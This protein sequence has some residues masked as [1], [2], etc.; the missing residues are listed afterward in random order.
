MKDLKNNRTREK[1]KREIVAKNKKDVSVHL[2][3]IDSIFKKRKYK[4]DLKLIL[5]ISKNK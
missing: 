3:N 2:L 5:K 4:R 1:T